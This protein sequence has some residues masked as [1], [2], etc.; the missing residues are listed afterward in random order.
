MWKN[1]RLRSI[2]SINFDN[3]VYQKTTEDEVHICRSQDGYTYP[4]VRAAA[5]I[6]EPW[7]PLPSSCQK[8]LEGQGRPR[9]DSAVC[10][11]AQAYQ[12]LGLPLRPLSFLAGSE[13]DKNEQID[14][15][16]GGREK[17][18]Q[19][20]GCGSVREDLPTRC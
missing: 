2:N 19:G 6:P 10:V 5:G 17:E 11:P 9:V 13:R 7:C 15:S 16:P 20:P 14:E 12:A 8:V 1:W 18:S 3:P 4:S